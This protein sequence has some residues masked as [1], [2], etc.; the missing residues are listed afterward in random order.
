MNLGDSILLDNEADFAL[1]LSSWSA[2]LPLISCKGRVPPPRLP[3]L[4]QR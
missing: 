2:M 4:V 1:H 3:H